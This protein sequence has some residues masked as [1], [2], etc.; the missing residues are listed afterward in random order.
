M[1]EEAKGMS[2]EIEKQKEKKGRE[3]RREG[4]RREEE[5]WRMTRERNGVKRNRGRE[6]GLRK[7]EQ[8]HK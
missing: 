3:G 1:E 4:G 2:K 7:V 5:G 6:R 8:R